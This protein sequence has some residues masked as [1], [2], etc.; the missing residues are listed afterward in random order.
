MEVHAASMA[1][2]WLLIESAQFRLLAPLPDFDIDG[3]KTKGWIQPTS[4]FNSALGQ[5]ASESVSL[6]T[7]MAE[8]LMQ[9]HHWFATVDSAR[10]F[11]AVHGHSSDIQ[12]ASATKP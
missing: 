4:I 1:G 9:R 8:R 11:S 2:H 5:K 12:Q 10:W 3:A 6:E 7:G